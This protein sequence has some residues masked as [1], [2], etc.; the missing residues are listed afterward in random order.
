MMHKT[1]VRREYNVAKNDYT[2]YNLMDLA[3]L[4][5]KYVS[6]SLGGSGRRPEAGPC[7]FEYCKTETPTDFDESEELTKRGLATM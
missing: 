7:E 3:W 6:D 2:F 4:I 1:N 5:E